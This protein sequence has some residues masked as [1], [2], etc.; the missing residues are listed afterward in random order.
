MQHKMFDWNCAHTKQAMF[1]AG[2]VN[3]YTTVVNHCANEIGSWQ[4]TAIK[5][6][7]ETIWK[8][9]RI[10]SNYENT[11][12]NDRFT[13]KNKNKPGPGLIMRQNGNFVVFHATKL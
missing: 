13:D 2:M 10:F 9:A 1:R 12:L 11:F 4:K 3:P 8:K 6:T 7:R 5:M